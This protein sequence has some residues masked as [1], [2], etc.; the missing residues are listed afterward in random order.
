[1]PERERER[2]TER[3]RERNTEREREKKIPLVRG[4]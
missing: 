2:K 3:E 4:A 1:M